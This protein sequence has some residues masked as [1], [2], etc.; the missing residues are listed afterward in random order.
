[1]SQTALRLYQ[2]RLTAAFVGGR[3][4]PNGTEVFLYVTDCIEPRLGLELYSRNGRRIGCA[5]LEFVHEEV[6]GA[7]R[8]GLYELTQLLSA[9]SPCPGPVAVLSG[10]LWN[11]L[12]VLEQSLA[13]SPFLSLEPAPTELSGPLSAA[14]GF[15]REI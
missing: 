2:S 5:V 13:A 15:L 9:D 14:G 12:E 6:D 1:M 11:R 10:V 8:K 7:L 3:A 4:S